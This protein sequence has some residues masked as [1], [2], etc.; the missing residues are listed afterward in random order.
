MMSFNRNHAIDS[1]ENRWGI[2]PHLHTFVAILMLCL[3][4]PYQA[5][6]IPKQSQTQERVLGKN[7]GREA[8]AGEKSEEKLRELKRLHTSVWNQSAHDLEFLECFHALETMGNGA[9]FSNHPREKAKTRQQEIECTQLREKAFNELLTKHIT[10]NVES[11]LKETL[12]HPRLPS[13]KEST[14]SDNDPLSD[15][16]SHCSAPEEGS[17]GSE[18]IGPE[19]VKLYQNMKKALNWNNLKTRVRSSSST[20]GLDIPPPPP[21]PL[22]FPASDF[23]SISGSDSESASD[24]E[25][26]DTRSLSS[27]TSF[28]IPPVAPENPTSAKG[29]RPRKADAFLPE[30]LIIQKVIPALNTLMLNETAEVDKDLNSWVTETIRSSGGNFTQIN[31]KIEHYLRVKGY[32]KSLKDRIRSTIKSSLG[33]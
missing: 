14:I 26:E 6:A 15:G 24:R 29:P 30:D 13:D 4:F 31:L 3:I 2:S 27:S 32:S 5:D 8:D 9:Y 7:R 16:G 21:P 22:V 25:F 12:L 10:E 28:L 23:E 19:H 18:S 11:K 20:T 17:L 33:S 1:L